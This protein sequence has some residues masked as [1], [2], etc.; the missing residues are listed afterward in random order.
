MKWIPVLAVL[1]VLLSEGSSR[2]AEVDQPT[3]GGGF[4]EA[5]IQGSTRL[6][7]EADLS[8]DQKAEALR[9]FLDQRYDMDNA[10]SFILGRYWAEAS[11]E[12]RHRYLVIFEDYL[13]ARY[14]AQFD[15][16][17]FHLAVVEVATG[18]AGK[19]IVRTVASR[20]GGLEIRVDW[21][22]VRRN[23]QRWL[24]SDVNVGGISLIELMRQDFAAV[25]R[26]NRGDIEALL[27]A[28]KRQTEAL[29]NAG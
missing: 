21:V 14:G 10:M 11:P 8:A 22:L 23:E 4:V 19:T 7:T 13:L 25:L 12:Q 27:A 1:A 24:I 2:A 18:V 20:D 6:R 15:E 29:G 9:R 16:I 28:I 3:D 26:A 17:A 5:F